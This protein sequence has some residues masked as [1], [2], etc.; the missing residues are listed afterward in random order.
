MY[1]VNIVLAFS[2]SLLA[3]V[4]GVLNTAGTDKSFL[5][6]AADENETWKTILDTIIFIDTAKMPVDVRRTM[7]Q[8]GVTAKLDGQN[9]PEP[10]SEEA[11]DPQ[12][13]R[14]KKKEVEEKK[15]EEE[16]RT[17]NATDNNAGGTETEKEL[18]T[19]V[20]TSNAWYVVRYVIR[21]SHAKSDPLVVF[22]Q[23]VFASAIRCQAFW[24][25]SLMID[26][27]N[28]LEYNKG[29]LHWYF[30]VQKY[31]K[32][33]RH[34]YDRL[35]V[36]LDIDRDLHKDIETLT[37]GIRVLLKKNVDDD[38]INLPDKEVINTI[39]N[40]IEENEKS[41]CEHNSL[42]E[43]IRRILNFPQEKINNIPEMSFWLFYGEDAL[44][45]LLKFLRAVEHA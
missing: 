17:R 40:L 1:D 34:E 18:P 24:F 6:A 35:K 16:L 21:I 31:I 27:L 19:E 3:V 30:T 33:Y 23:A 12:W 7:R 25:F 43:R 36:T 14:S 8:R 11:V 9:S 2:T 41:T 13:T 32:Q 29:R 38:T 45:K 22:G 10:D 44:I 37:D 5:I 26:I 28:R 39:M 20:I 4:P 15:G 42:M